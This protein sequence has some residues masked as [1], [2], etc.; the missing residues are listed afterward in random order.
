MPTPHISA[1]D[2]DF[3]PVCLMPGDPR[4]AR[5]IADTF[6]TD[7][8]MVTDVRNMEGFTGT[9]EGR[10]VSVM[11]HGMGV[12]SVSIYANE[13]VREYGVQTLIR[14]G[15]CGSIRADLALRSVVVAL[16]ASTDSNVNRVRFG[17][18]DLA[19]VADF[20]LARAAVDAAAALSVPVRVGTVFT[21]DLFY[22]P[23][24]AVN[25]LAARRGA[26][27]VEMEAAGLYGVAA[28]HGVRALTLLTVSDHLL[29]DAHLSSDERQRSFD[30]MV[31][32]ALATVIA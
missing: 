16:G 13:L 3:A 31:R 8:R 11:A 12:P 25:D 32:I 4:R 28:E 17:G 15:S 10:P 29:D 23:D 9:Y 21:S 27:A 6:L 22:A 19:A 1:A 5:Y 30:D 20:D 2:G 24:P 7:A 26:L 18:H 14:I